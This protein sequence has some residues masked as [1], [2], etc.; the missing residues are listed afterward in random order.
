[1]GRKKTPASGLKPFRDGDDLAH[2]LARTKN[3]L[4][5]PL[6]DGPEVIDRCE[7]QR[8]ELQAADLA[9]PY[10]YSQKI[11]SASAIDSMAKSRWRSSDAPRSPLVYQPQCFPESRAVF[12]V[13]PCS[14]SA[15]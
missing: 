13:S 9:D 7:R 12:R 14:R 10:R 5:M 2:R 4:L 15:R 8:L 1:M 11:A 3:H 6:G